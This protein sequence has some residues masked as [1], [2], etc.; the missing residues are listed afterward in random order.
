MV[1]Y[2]F[3]NS[4][5]GA[6]HVERGTPCE[7]ASG[8]YTAEGGAFHAIAVA[9]G[10]GDWRCFRS[11]TGAELAVSVALDFLKE[12]AQEKLSAPEAV[13][14]RFFHDMFTNP[15]YRQLELRRWTD[16]V[17][18][19]WSDAVRLD[20]DS[21]PPDPE[22][23]DSLPASLRTPEAVP[24]IYGATLIAAL[25]IP[26][27]LV[28]FQQGDG[29]CEVF[30]ADGTVNQPIPWDER[31][32]GNVTTSLCDPDA[33]VGF[34]S[35]VLDLRQTPVIACYLGTD[36]V[37][38]AYRDTYTGLGES[39]TLMGGVHT[40]YKALSCEAAERTPE[41]L[42][43]Y[44]SETLPGFSARGQYGYGGSWD[45]VSVAGIVC[46]EALSPF[47]DAWRVDVRRY[48]L[49]EGLFWKGDELRSGARKHEILS[50][51]V[52]EARS[53]L[54]L[55]K[56]EYSMYHEE[57]ASL[58]VSKAS[59]EKTPGDHSEELSLLREEIRQRERLQAVCDGS[60]KAR[61]Q[62]FE[63]AE[64]AFSDYDAKYQA[65]KAERRQILSELLALS[66]AEGASAKDGET[67]NET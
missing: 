6:S 15:R 32:V 53:R 20:Y 27:A 29:R 30:Y 9:D 51:R 67:P 25:W 33:A 7:D 47:V 21:R 2:S 64:R 42:S 3:S 43:E 50:K 61:R 8:A 55:V 63:E 66:N 40:F 23:L 17:L 44:L 59:L 36:G 24:H 12:V 41:A 14:E 56:E 28:L 60:M 13:R 54:E 65:T 39:H 48:G 4:A 5:R 37:E 31:C 11:H 58:M 45:D 1:T 16:V 38:D 26:P 46:P 49:E 10:H 19:R 18:S 22:E 52:E 34:R 35:C 62:E 57:L